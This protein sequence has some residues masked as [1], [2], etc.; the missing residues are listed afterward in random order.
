VAD[1]DQPKR[2][3]E[4]CRIGKPDPRAELADIANGAVVGDVVFQEILPAS[5]LGSR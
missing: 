3:G 1:V 4:Q 5:K 2:I